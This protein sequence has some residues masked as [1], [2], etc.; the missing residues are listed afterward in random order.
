MKKP[1][2]IISLSCTMIFFLNTNVRAQEAENKV[3]TIAVPYGMLDDKTILDGFTKKYSTLSKE[4]ILAMIKDD[5]LTAYKSAAAIRVFKIGY[6]REVIGKEK[7]QI[8]KYLLRKLNRTD[9]AFVSVE[10]LHTLCIL[11]RYRYFKSMIPALIQKID[12][13]NVLVSDL[14]FEALNELIDAGN[15]RTREARIVFN[16]L[17]KVLF[18]SRKRL[19]SITEPSPKLNKKLKLV[20]WSIKVLGAQELKKLP[21][22]VISLL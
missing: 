2:L 1:I 17:R 18:L 16:T 9:S 11:D 7:K 5:A 15:N 22:E 3:E 13:Y 14:A 10:I 12:H 19:A 21:K 8:E 6:S 20:R 4:I